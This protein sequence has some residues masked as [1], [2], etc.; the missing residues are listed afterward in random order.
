MMIKLPKGIRV[1]KDSEVGI[2]YVNMHGG[3]EYQ[4]PKD[5]NQ[6]R[7]DLRIAINIGRNLREGLIAK[8]DNVQKP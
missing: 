1:M 5:T 8:E 3:I 6:A 4:C 2:K 7:R